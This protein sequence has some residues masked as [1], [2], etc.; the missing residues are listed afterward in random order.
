[1]NYYDVF[2]LDSVAAYDGLYTYHSEHIF[3]KG[4]L[5]S[6]PFG[7]ANKPKEALIYQVSSIR[8]NTKSILSKEPIGRI[9][10]ERTEVL[11]ELSDYYLTP[12]S[13]MLRLAL[14]KLIGKKVQHVIE[15]TG[16][17]IPE[18]FV[19]RAEQFVDSPEMLDE[20]LLREGY[21]FRRR[22]REEF[23]LYSTLTK[24]ELSAFYD[25]IPN[26]YTARREIVEKLLKAYPAPIPAHSIPVALRNFFS[27]EGS[28][29]LTLEKEPFHEK[30]LA[31]L[32]EE[33]KKVFQDIVQSRDPLHLLW[34]VSA[35]GKSFLFLHLVSAMLEK[36]KKCLVLYPD[37]RVLQAA[38]PNYREYFGNKVGVYQGRMTPA[39]L[40]Q[41]LQDWEEDRIQVLLGTRGALLLPLSQLGLV[42]MDECQEDEYLSDHPSYDARKAAIVFAQKLGIKTVFSSSTP[43]IELLFTQNLQRH[44]L[45]KPFL[46]FAGPVPTSAPLPSDASLSDTAISEIKKSLDDK[47][48]ILLLSTRAGYASSVFCRQC[49]ALRRCPNC[50]RPLLYFRGEAI[51]KCQHCSLR[52]D[53]SS[54]CEVCAESGLVFEARGIEKTEEE[55]KS[56]FTDA[57]ILRMDFST[58]RQARAFEE[59]EA[60]FTEGSFDILLGNKLITRGYEDDFSL[61]IALDA[62]AT[63]YLPEHRAGLKTFARLYQFFGRA[64][65]KGPAR[66]LLQTRSENNYVVEALL[67]GDLWG[68][69]EEEIRIRR[70][71]QLPPF[72]SEI[73]LWFTD[74]DKKR[75]LLDA[76]E[77]SKKLK[78]R[79][80]SLHM[81]LYEPIHAYRRGLY[82]HRLLMRFDPSQRPDSEFLLS[83]LRDYPTLR[84]RVDPEY[85]LY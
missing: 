78:D 15:R 8:E 33:Q 80:P 11:I 62:Q 50:D 35:S 7:V 68:F 47:E 26:R 27:Q 83:L 29:R 24:E 57:R 9:S 4:E 2:L 79:Y 49:G 34:G 54:S 13:A 1:M 63:L 55:L 71:Q 77:V 59:W 85:L 41:T 70:E 20:K 48:K 73:L 22:R 81:V 75:V 25:E 52:F 58:S 19:S 43:P 31:P 32:T 66:S 18:A 42:L 38:L 84:Y 30:S 82:E 44:L 39:Q 10:P 16:K 65:R 37:N 53:P 6:V 40:S 14:P 17:P 74:P 76:E 61:A 69:Y 28:F 72:T 67:R 23:F 3:R 60:T 36:G 12:R 21:F 56:L 64:G 46:P 5:V 51:L 45:R